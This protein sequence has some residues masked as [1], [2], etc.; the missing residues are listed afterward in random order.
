MRR[1]SWNTRLEEPYSG[2]PVR[3]L[4]WLAQDE[5][6]LAMRG[7]ACT[8][9]PSITEGFGLATA[10]SV[11][12]GI[13]TL[14]QPVGGQHVLKFFPNARPVSLTTD[15]RARLYRVWADLSTNSIDR[16]T[17]WSRHEQS[18]R[19]LVEKWVQAI[20]ATV[21]EGVQPSEPH[22]RCPEPAAQYRWANRLMRCLDA[23]LPVEEQSQ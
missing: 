11:Y 18:L 10:E 1:P 21:L 4:P 14:Y 3:W 13:T 2:L 12:E 20:R 7:A 15:D 5:L 6:L 9:L 19:P 17:A 16:W 8:V 22:K 23:R